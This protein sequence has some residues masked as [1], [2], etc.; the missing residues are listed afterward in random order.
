M[1]ML[2]ARA[3]RK[4]F[5][6]RDAR[7]GAVLDGVDLEVPEGQF[8][9]L[10]GPSGSGK[11]TLLYLLGALDRPTSGE[12][13]IK[14]QS[15]TDL[16]DDGLA[17]LRLE[18]IGFVFQFHFLNEV[19]TAEENVMV[20]ALLAGRS[21]R[22]ARA[23]ARAGLEALG[24]G[25][26][27]SHRPSRLSGGEQQRVAMARALVNRPRLLL[28]DEP[29]GNLDGASGERVMETLQEAHRRDGLTIVLVTHN[30]ELVARA[31]RHV[32]MRD[33]RLHHPEGDPG[34]PSSAVS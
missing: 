13:R 34:G 28:A 31:E 15:T 25:H 2:E 16:R 22:E 21:D 1:T 29:T 18:T 7:S 10:T 23:M 27:L 12:V 17:R 3:V 33:G 6:E 19:L 24:L 20:P 14:G 26:R 5:G 4:V 30:M 11:S 8:V 9:A 32:A